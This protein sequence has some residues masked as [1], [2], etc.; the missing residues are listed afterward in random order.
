MDGL[1]FAVEPGESD[2]SDI[3]ILKS[4]RKGVRIISISFR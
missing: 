1:Y 4:S 3:T 2:E